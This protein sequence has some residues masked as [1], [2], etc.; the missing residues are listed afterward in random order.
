MVTLLQ[1]NCNNIHLSLYVKRENYYMF[2]SFFDNINTVLL[3]IYLGKASTFICTEFIS[4]FNLTDPI[5]NSYY[6]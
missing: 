6:E 3:I 5:I 1:K 2:L 4:P